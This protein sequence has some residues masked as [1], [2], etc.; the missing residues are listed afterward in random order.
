MAN[1]LSSLTGVVS[2]PGDTTALFNVR[3]NKGAVQIFLKY[4]K[5]NGTKVVISSIEFIVPQ[6]GAAVLY[7]VPDS[8]SSGSTLGAYTLTLDAD[9][10]YI[11]TMAYVPL[12][13]TSMKVTIAWTDGTTQ[14][15]QIDAKGD[16]N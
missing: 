10:N 12:E 1:A 11:I 5:G 4:A 13:A 9:G 16:V 6:L 14:T 3:H 8:M 2:A 7:K 15:L